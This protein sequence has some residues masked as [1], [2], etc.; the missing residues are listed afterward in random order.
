MKLIIYLLVNGLAIFAASQILPGVT[1]DTFWTA[2]LV[3]IVLGVVNVFLKP[4][5]VILTLP[6]TIITLGLFSFIINAVL[7]LLVDTLV[8]GFQVGGFLWALLFSF[9]ISLVSTFLTS[10]TKTS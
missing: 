1:I 10:L 6:L 8:P 4:F 7:V 5:L 3:A 9:V 2:I